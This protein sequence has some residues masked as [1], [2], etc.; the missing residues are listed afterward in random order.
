MKTYHDTLGHDPIVFH[1]CDKPQDA[2]VLRTF[3]RRNHLLGLDTES[4]GLNCYRPDWKL[5]A[6]QVGNA[7]TA[8]IIPAWQVTLIELIVAYTGRWVMHNAPHD[9]RCIDRHLGYDTG[10]RCSRETHILSHY[11]DS[12]NKEEGGIG[13]GLKE[14]AVCLVSPDAG[15]WEKELNVEFKKIRVPVKGEFYKSGQKRGQQKTRIITLAEGWGLIDPTNPA[16]IKYAGA[17]PVLTFRL[18][19]ILFPYLTNTELYQR[20]LRLQRYMDVLYRRAML[21]DVAYTE[22]LDQQYAKEHAVYAAKAKAYGCANVESGAQ[23]ANVLVN[24]GATLTD[25]TKKGAWQTTSAVLRALAAR[26]GGKVA[27]FIHVVL[28][29]KQLSK[30]RA[31]YTQNFLLERDVNDRVHPSVNILGARTA[32]MSVSNPALQQL[33]TKDNSDDLAE[34]S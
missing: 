22:D 20:D 29:A 31:A 1:Y 26:S 14:L 11:R 6:V 3:L 13:H 18:W 8:F 27:D 16:Y 9:I 32:R 34:I 5:R 30:R 15:K 23:I 25:K 7:D 2:K 17:D 28:T 24:L 12:R 10:M 19:P 4:T 21:I 33:P